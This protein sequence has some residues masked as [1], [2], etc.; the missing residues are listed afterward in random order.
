MAINLDILLLLI[1]LNAIIMVL[2]AWGQGREELTAR[3]RVKVGPVTQ[4]DD[5]NQSFQAAVLDGR[6]WAAVSL[7]VQSPK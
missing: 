2:R 3:E 4:A 6:R 7:P 1:I 5:E